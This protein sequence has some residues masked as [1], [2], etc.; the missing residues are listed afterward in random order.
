MILKE[1]NK[2]NSNQKTQGKAIWPL[3]DTQRPPMGGSDE[4][5]L[6]SKCTRY[7]SHDPERKNKRNSNQKTQRKAILPLGDTRRPPWRGS[8]EFFSNSKCA[9]YDSHHLSYDSAQKQFQFF[10]QLYDYSPFDPWGP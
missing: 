7:H 4:I 8:D 2:R 9:R 6:N 5:C 3:G 10:K 1:K